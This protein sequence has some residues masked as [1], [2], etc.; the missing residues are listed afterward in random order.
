MA[1]AKKGNK[2]NAKSQKKNSK[3]AKKPAKKN[4]TTLVVKK[5]HTDRLKL[6]KSKPTPSHIDL[7][8]EKEDFKHVV[9]IAGRDL[10][11]YMTLSQ[12][13]DLIFGIN[14]RISDSIN[15]IYTK[16]TKKIIKKIGYLNDEDIEIIQE[17]LDNLDKYV[18]NWLLNRSKLREGGSKHL[19]M[20]DLKLAQRKELQRLGQIKSYRGLRLQWGLPVRGQRTRST[21]RRS[22]VVG[23][24]KKK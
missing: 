7:S 24:S 16:K 4:S 9:R 14:N 12:G 21:F 22:G 10:P 13:L 15:K 19:I 11:G 18:P 1:K 3:S 6:Q 17:I 20:A 23:V 2:S 5:T 8:K